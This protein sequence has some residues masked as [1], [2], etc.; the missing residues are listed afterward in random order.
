MPSSHY[1]KLAAMRTLDLSTLPMS[2]LIALAALG[3]V[4]IS[5]LV[6]AL[7]SLIRRPQPLVSLNKWVWAAII[8]FINMIGPILY[9]TIGRVRQAP[10]TSPVTQSHA[11]RSASEVAE[12]LYGE[13]SS[14]ES[15][16]DAQPTDDH[17]A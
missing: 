11:A 2:A 15:V 4:Q 6:V 7:V 13:A 3:A 14:H 5:L 10:P 17:R 8:V 16:D 1:D 9:L 12:A